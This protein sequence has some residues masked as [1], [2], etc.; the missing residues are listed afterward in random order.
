MLDDQ[1]RQRL[2]AQLQQMQQQIEQLNIQ[3]DEFSDW[4]D[5]K[6]FRADAVT[7]L[8][9]VREIR[10]NLMALQQP[11]SV[12]RQQWLAQRIGDQM[13]ALY[14]GIRWFSRP[15]VKGAAQSRK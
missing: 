10:S 3:E 14:Q 13:N 4:F 7:P 2:L 12:S 15:P 1:L 8:C 11:C 6:L 5:S 9:Y